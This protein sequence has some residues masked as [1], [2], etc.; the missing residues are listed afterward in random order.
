[1]LDA[2]EAQD[3]LASASPVAATPIHVAEGSSHL[4]APDAEAKLV[5][6]TFAPAAL[7]AEDEGSEG[8]LRA[9][10]DDPT[11]VPLG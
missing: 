6:D 11:A 9:F 7:H 10:S 2:V 1:M 3:E 5:L 4:P 8:P